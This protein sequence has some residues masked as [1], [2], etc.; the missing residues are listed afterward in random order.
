MLDYK[1]ELDGGSCSKEN[2]DPNLHGSLLASRSNGKDN[3][4][5]LL[6]LLKFIPRSFDFHE[7]ALCL[8]RIPYDQVWDTTSPLG[9]FFTE[10]TANHR[11]NGTPQTLRFCEIKIGPQ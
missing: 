10:Q 9:V 11:Q 6:V 7:R 1:T 4:A 5:Y 8:G 3:K 2:V